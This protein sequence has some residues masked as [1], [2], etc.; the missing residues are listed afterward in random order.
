[1]ISA[2][3]HLKR[4]AFGSAIQCYGAIRRKFEFGVGVRAFNAVLLREKVERFDWR[5]IHVPVAQ[6]V[7]LEV[8]R[9]KRAERNQ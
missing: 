4:K 5:S 8:G 3:R 6:Q 7:R 1:M 2:K 9:G